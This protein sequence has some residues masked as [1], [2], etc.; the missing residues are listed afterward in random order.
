MANS[1]PKI[2]CPECKK[3]TIWHESNPHR[4]FCSRRCKMID[5]GEWLEENRAI[6][7]ENQPSEVEQFKSQE[8]WN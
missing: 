8:D 7:G 2:K 3:L 1:P 6:P 4:P 5:L